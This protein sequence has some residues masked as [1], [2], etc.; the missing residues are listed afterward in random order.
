[1]SEILFEK[2]DWSVNLEDGYGPDDKEEIIQ[3]SIQAISRTKRGHFVNV[4]T[5]G[6]CGDPEFWLVPQLEKRLA[7]QDITI[8][9]MVYIDQC[10][11]GG[12]V[13]RVYR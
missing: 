2:G 10:G 4:V 3:E 11:C 1:M 6:P 12:Y 5:P 8:E 9:R 13:T 7:Q